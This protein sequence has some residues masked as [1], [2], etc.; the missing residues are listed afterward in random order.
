MKNAPFLLIVFVIALLSS[1]SGDD[2]EPTGINEIIV[3]QIDY[4][5]TAMNGSGITVKPHLPETVT[6][7]P[8]F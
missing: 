4:N 6:I 3:D 1:C 8:A 5:L 7:I 2:I